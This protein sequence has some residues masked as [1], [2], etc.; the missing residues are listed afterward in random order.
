[1]GNQQLHQRLSSKPV[2]TIIETYLSKEIN[3]KEAREKLEIGKTRFFALVKNYQ[4][5]SQR[6]NIEY[7]REKA[8]RGIKE[9][10][11]QQILREL[12]AEK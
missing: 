4:K 1:M 7:Q 8:T 11:E 9:L 12:A 3:S 2:K 5:N 6:F 10:S